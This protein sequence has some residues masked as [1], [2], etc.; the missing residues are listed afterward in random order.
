MSLVDQITNDIKE[1]MKARDAGRTTALRNIRAAFIEA[2]KVDGAPTLS[3]EKAEA[4]LRSQAKRRLESI[5][6]YVKGGRED[7]AEPERAELIVI[8]SYLPQLADEATTRAWAVEAVA[9]VGATTPKEMGKVMAA[10]G[11]AHGAD[12]DKGLASR[13]VKEL[14]AG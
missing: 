3:D 8:N 12:I 6:A 2:L 11:A 5:D 4:I 14:L 7:L 13:I 1:A 9:S 10:L